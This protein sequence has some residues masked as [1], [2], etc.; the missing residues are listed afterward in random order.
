MVTVF[1]VCSGLGNVHRGYESFT[2]E[3]FEALERETHT[4]IEVFLFKGGG[5]SQ[6]KEFV[7]PNLPRASWLAKKLGKILEK[8]SYFI[9]QFTFALSLLTYIY[10][11]RPHVIFF[12]DFS[13]GTTLWH[14]R[15][16]TGLPY[17]LIFCNGASYGPPFSRTDFVQHST[18]VHYH[19][20]LDAGESPSKHFLVPQGIGI[21]DQLKTLSQE[22]RF[23]LC[24]AL[25][26]PSDRPII[27][28]VAAID[29]TVK[30]IDYLISEVA[31]LSEPRPFLIMLGHQ[32]TESP[33]IVNMAKQL[34]GNENFLIKTVRMSEVTKYYQVADIFVLTS[35]KEG[36]GRVFVEA[37]S[38]GLPCI[39]HDY[40]VARFV[41]KDE[42]YFGNF[43][44]AGSLASL[45]SDVLSQNDDD[46]KHRRH[47]SV[48][49]SFSWKKLHFDYFKMIN[50]CAKYTD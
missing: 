25:E 41:L 14:C 8:D 33:E 9:E 28:S 47:Q 50:H 13:V 5:K 49:E 32:T 42:G 27:L 4:S 46:S 11:K 17:K 24:R 16:M 30:R 40:D 34:L 43:K 36:F 3:C 20:A 45:I 35:L 10:L 12:S 6:N 22:E 38:Y 18:P 23:S 26:L 21:S 37:M 2:Q 48:Y 1:L 31:Q 15:R 39:A 7:L 44:L 29:K 19:M